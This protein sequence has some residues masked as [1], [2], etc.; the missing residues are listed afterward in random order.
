[1]IDESANVIKKYKEMRDKEVS[2]TQNSTIT[3]LLKFFSPYTRAFKINF[4]NGRREALYR[5]VR[6]GIC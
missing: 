6:V 5:K 1:M 4:A 2:I 3:I